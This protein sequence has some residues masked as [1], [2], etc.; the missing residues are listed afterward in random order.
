MQIQERNS[1]IAITLLYTIPTSLRHTH[2]KAPH[3]REYMHMS[4]VC[5]PREIYTWTCACPVVSA[6]LVIGTT[7]LLDMT[8]TSRDPLA[9]HL[10][11]TW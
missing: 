11:I 9:G 4:R 7:P 10:V 8:L 5:M 6:C 1:R 2:V 3:H